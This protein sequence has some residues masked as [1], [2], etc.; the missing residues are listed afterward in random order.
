MTFTEQFKEARKSL[1]LSQQ[2]LAD[3]TLIPRRT[4]QSWESDKSDGRNAPVWSQ[5]LVL[6][7]L[8]RLKHAE[9]IQRLCDYLRETGQDEK[10]REAAGMDTAPSIIIELITKGQ[11]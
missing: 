1:G 5:P 2:K 7:E 9:D 10:L 6:R 4:I 3:I 8:E 11:E